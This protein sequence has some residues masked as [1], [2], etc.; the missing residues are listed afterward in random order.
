MAFEFYKEMIADNPDVLRYFEEA[1]PFRELETS[2]SVWRPARRDQGRG[3]GDLRAIPWGFG[4]M[5]KSPRMPAWFGVGFALDRFARR[6][7]KQSVTSTDAGSVSPFD[8]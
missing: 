2:E 8:D 1:T 6:G 5:Q 3:L 7:T 4:W